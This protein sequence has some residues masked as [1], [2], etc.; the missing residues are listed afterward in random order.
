MS[1]KLYFVPMFRYGACEIYLLVIH[2]GL[3]RLAFTSENFM[4]VV[5]HFNIRMLYG[6]LLQIPQLMKEP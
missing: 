6:I 1:L 4:R 5:I 3:N 2:F